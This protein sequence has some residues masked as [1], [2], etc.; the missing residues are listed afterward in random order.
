MGS[1][2]KKRKHAQ[3]TENKIR[4]FFSFIVNLQF[5]ITVSYYHNMLM[6]FVALRI[7]DSFTYGK[8]ANNVVADM[9]VYGIVL[10]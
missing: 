3:I 6:S 10:A 8:T 5:L 4:I 9:A 7:F 2:A 1:R